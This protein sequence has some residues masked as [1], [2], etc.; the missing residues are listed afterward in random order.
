M[1]VQMSNHTDSNNLPVP[2][3]TPVQNQVTPFP[4]LIH[5]NLASRSTPTYPSCVSIHATTN[6]QIKTN[7]T[8]ARSNI[9]STNYVNPPSRLSPLP[10]R[11]PRLATRSTNC[12]S[13]LRTVT[14]KRHRQSA[15]SQR[16]FT[17]SINPSN[18][19]TSTSSQLSSSSIPSTFHIPSQ[20]L[21]S[22]SHAPS[23]HTNTIQHH[24]PP[25]T[26]PVSHRRQFPNPYTPSNCPIIEYR[27]ISPN[28]G[29]HLQP[30]FPDTN[31]EP[32]PT[33]LDMR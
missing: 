22:S 18:T 15:S 1:I 19:Y 6:N 29:L 24:A 7:Y 11:S 27:L 8:R 10:R 33:N 20:P 9:I 4:Y 30:I 23:A 5:P 31:P 3:Q 14:H 16:F 2:H 28:I 26:Y 32:S 17:T 12:P 21:S 25:S 13:P